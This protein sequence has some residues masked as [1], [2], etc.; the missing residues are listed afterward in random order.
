MPRPAQMCPKSV[1]RPHICSYRK[2][3]FEKTQVQMVVTESGPL[4]SLPDVLKCIKCGKAYKKK[5]NFNKH[6]E[7]CGELIINILIGTVFITVAIKGV[8]FLL[9]FWFS[10]D[11]GDIKRVRI[12]V[13]WSP[14]GGM[15]T[16]H[17]TYALHRLLFFLSC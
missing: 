7:I 12:M 5:T 11:G 8:C 17:P 13:R 1:Y 2:W 10:R 15:M 16:P 4:P 3:T 6:S 9:A 14:P